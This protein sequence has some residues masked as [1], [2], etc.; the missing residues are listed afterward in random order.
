MQIPLI[1]KSLVTRFIKIVF[2]L[3]FVFPT[4]FCLENAGIALDN[5]IYGLMSLFLLFIMISKR[6][7]SKTNVFFILAV[8]ILSLIH[9]EATPLHLL[10]LLVLDHICTN[11]E[12]Y[13]KSFQDLKY[14]RNI[15]IL[16][17]A[18]YSI[19]YH[20]YLDRFAY[21]GVGEVNISGLGIFLL[22]VIVLKQNRWIGFFILTFG[23]LTF[24]RNYLLALASLFLINRYI[25]KKDDRYIN[26][27]INR[28][29]FFKIGLFSCIAL[30]FVSVGFQIMYDNDLILEYAAGA[31]RFMTIFEISNYHRFTVNTNVL[32]IYVEHPYLIFTGIPIKDFAEY[33]L[34]ICKLN[35]HDYANDRPHN[36]FFSYLQIYGGHCILI[37]MY[38]V[39]IFKKTVNR[40]NFGLFIC[41]M[42]YGVFLGMGLSGYW[43]CLS[44][45]ALII[46]GKKDNIYG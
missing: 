1:K 4:G 19:L 34:E 13:I 37:F 45:A 40:Y 23:M 15:G 6:S 29:N 41:I 27:L 2:I 5:Y 16:G 33:N 28:I 18:V 14:Y 12:F 46:T 30:F 36:Y 42:I 9:K 43:L 31:S 38:M 35:G 17:I 24:S 25:E 39:R 26:N 8:F 22:G 3:A 21:L 11:K 44:V 10:S 20:G 32:E 7:P